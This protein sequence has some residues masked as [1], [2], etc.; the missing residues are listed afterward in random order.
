MIFQRLLHKYQNASKGLELQHGNESKT[1]EKNIK[2][3]SNNHKKMHYM[4]KKQK[5]NH[6]KMHYMYKK[7]KQKDKKKYFMLY[8]RYD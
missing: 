3:P 5:P 8:T 2:I 7:Q 6:K 4:Y 1:L